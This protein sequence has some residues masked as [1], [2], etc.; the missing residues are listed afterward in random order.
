MSGSTILFRRDADFQKCPDCQTS[1]SLR[2]SRSRNFLEAVIKRVTFFKIYRCR[3]CGWRGY[4]SSLVFTFG[5]F[6]ILLLYLV[7]AVICGFV[8]RMVINRFL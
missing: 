3:K 6:K 5:S 1:G 7:I 4:R 8:V 2:N